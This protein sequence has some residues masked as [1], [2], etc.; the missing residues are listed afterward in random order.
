MA[1]EVKHDEVARFKTAK[2]E[3]KTD[4]SSNVV[5][6][7][8]T[9]AMVIVNGDAYVLR[10][11]YYD[12]KEDEQDKQD[13]QDKQETVLS[14]AILYLVKNISGS[15]TH[16]KLQIYKT[17]SKVHKYVFFKHLNS[18]TYHDSKFY[19]VDLEEKIYRL[20]SKGRI[21]RGYTV[22][23]SSFDNNFQ[24]STIEHYKDNLYILGV[25]KNKDTHTRKYWII[26][27]DAKQ[28]NNLVI[29]GSF[30]CGE[31]EQD[32]WVGNDICYD[33]GTQLFYITMSYKNETEKICIKNKIFTYNLSTL[34]P[35]A[36]TT[37]VYQ[38]TRILQ[39]GL[40]DNTESYEYEGISI[41][42]G[43]KYVAAE[44]KLREKKKGEEDD[45]IVVLSVKK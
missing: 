38:P 20:S 27:F 44:Q 30:I 7:T 16:S 29:R 18:I 43:R 35:Y 22:K 4:D 10:Y 39:E 40:S 42:N 24:L 9:A 15:E 3:S 14:P 21:E 23:N 17:V 37:A 8:T 33:A 32:G 41:L 25:L 11:K 6:C 2:C 26:E 12:D 1:T 45:A 36:H 5:K 13:K 31:C 28:N 19:L 34:D